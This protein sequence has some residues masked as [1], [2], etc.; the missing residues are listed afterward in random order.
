MKLNELKEKGLVIFE[1][2]FNK[3]DM[4][5][6]NR[7][8]ST[9]P[10]TV[11]NVKDKGWHNW[12]DVIKLG[13]TANLLTEVDWAYHWAVTPKDNVIIN[14][15]ILP[16]ITKISDSVFESS[17]WDW[18]KTNRYIMSNYK[19]DMDVSP[20]LDAPYLWPQKLETQ[21][22]KYLEPGILSLTFMIPLIDFT[23]NNGATAYVLGT[24]KY[25]WDTAD[26]NEAKP[27]HKTFFSDNYVQPS[28]PVG[29]FACFY[30][31]CLHSVMPNYTDEIRRGI[32][33]RAIRQD[34][35]DEMERLGLG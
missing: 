7:T 33:Y 2:M 15:T 1:N 19:H 34:A 21:M 8:A 27:V 25:I 4:E 14:E 22:A 17:E 6:L 31:N 12:S 24:H 28:V 5:S 9:L 26:W 23:V 16:V 18:Q 11:G 13:E 20:H 29:S 30:G 3:Q 35:L 10:P 32:I